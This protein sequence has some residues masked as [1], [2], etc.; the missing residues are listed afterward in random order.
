MSAARGRFCDLL[1]FLSKCWVGNSTMF[2]SQS[3]MRKEREAILKHSSQ[4]LFSQFQRLEPLWGIVRYSLLQREN[5]RSAEVAAVLQ[6]AFIVRLLS[7]ANDLTPESMACEIQSVV[8]GRNQIWF[9]E[10]LGKLT[11]QPN[12]SRASLVG[13][14]L[15]SRDWETLQTYHGHGNQP[16]QLE[17]HC[18]L[19]GRCCSPV[20]YLHGKQ[21]LMLRVQFTN[22]LDNLHKTFSGS[23]VCASMCAKYKF[24]LLSLHWEPVQLVLFL[25]KRLS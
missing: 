8:P 17:N 18:H 4:K 15:R 1:N 19:N 22:L 16:L 14:L 10:S 24:N 3:P 20:W 9:A 25:L 7:P 5:Q 23:W 21:S 6:T 11:R 12:E 2:S 13:F